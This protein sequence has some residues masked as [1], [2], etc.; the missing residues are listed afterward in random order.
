MADS[1]LGRKTVRPELSIGYFVA[2]CS[3]LSGG[4]AE[5]W[6]R[7][8][9]RPGLDFVKENRAVGSYSEHVD[10]GHDVLS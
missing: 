9:S 4:S 10:A 8:R 1:R 2:L 3:R 5:N 7:L 6:S